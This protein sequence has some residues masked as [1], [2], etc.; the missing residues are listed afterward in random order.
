MT[1][2]T[3]LKILRDDP[4][5]DAESAIK[6]LGPS[7]FPNKKHHVSF[8]EVKDWIECSWRHKK[9]HVE[10]IELDG[11][12]IHT[13]F[14]QVVHDAMEHYIILDPKDRKPIDAAP[15]V[16][17][18]RSRMPALI[19]KEQ[20]EKKRATLVKNV[21]KFSKEMPPLLEQAPKWLDEQFPGWVAL[22][23]EL[24]LYEPIKGQDIR[25]KGFVDGI[26][27]VPK[28]RK[29]RTKL[30]QKGKIRLDCMI[31]NQ[32]TA[33]YET[34]EGK[35]DYWILDWKTTDWGWKAEKKRDKT[36]QLQIMLYKIFGC[37]ALGMDLKDTKCGFVL[38]K[39]RPRKSDG[40]QC[41]LIPVSVGPKAQERALKQL[42]SM[43]NQ[44]KQKRA[45]KNR[46]SCLFCRY[47]NTEHC[48]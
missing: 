14:G 33:V 36:Q 23:A 26:L 41:E 29:K 25:F 12:S 21:E 32:D 1:E 30:Q 13:E 16:E 24:K 35:F 48:L 4:I 18:F 11:P 42:N 47:K 7:T 10:K 28:R 27:K 22:G 9:K 39:R 6:L 43:I 44:V 38:L 31:E 5:V 46:M 2:K 45:I 37:Q 34:V 40:S 15:Y 8:S 3:R 17:E 20:N 19:A